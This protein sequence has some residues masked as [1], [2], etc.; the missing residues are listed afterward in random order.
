MREVW[1]TTCQ[2]A[3]PV[4]LPL[5]R[6]LKKR[7]AI[8]NIFKNCCCQSI[9]YK[10]G[11]FLFSFLFCLAVFAHSSSWYMVKLAS[12]DVEELGLIASPS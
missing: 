5:E 12:H 4:G 2:E 9:G 11:S 1:M 7:R 10:Q 3:F 6:I 8:C